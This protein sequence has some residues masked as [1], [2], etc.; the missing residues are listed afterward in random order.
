MIHQIRSRHI[1]ETPI[2]GNASLSSEK[3]E[4][5]IDPSVN[6]NVSH[7][8]SDQSEPSSRIIRQ[9]RSALFGQLSSR[10][11]GDSHYDFREPCLPDKG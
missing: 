9:N 6:L 2:A 7:Y 1:A 11:I 8:R 10:P 4:P 5:S 3:R